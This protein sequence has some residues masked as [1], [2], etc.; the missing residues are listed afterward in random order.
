MIVVGNDVIPISMLRDKAEIAQAAAENAATP[1]E[2]AA[3]ET[4]AKGKPAAKGKAK[5]A[6]T[7]KDKG[8]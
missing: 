2:D 4:D 6:D 5:A 8:K 3:A 1:Q 7:S